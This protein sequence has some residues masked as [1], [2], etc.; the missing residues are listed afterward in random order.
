MHN[1]SVFGYSGYFSVYPL[2]IKTKMIFE[3]FHVAIF[4]NIGN[5]FYLLI[6]NKNKLNEIF[7]ASYLH[8]VIT[9]D[10]NYSFP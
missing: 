3:A 10:V 4:L 2:N 1:F 9:V 7:V 8:K 5:L 6:Q